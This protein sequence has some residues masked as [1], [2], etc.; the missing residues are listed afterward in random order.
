MLAVEECV[1][2]WLDDEDPLVLFAW[3]KPP[4][5]DAPLPEDD[6]PPVLPLALVE[7]CPFDCPDEEEL[8]ATTEDVDELV[9]AF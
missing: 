6:C 4:F 2:D 1:P 7:C 9:A 5:C 3:L 8:F